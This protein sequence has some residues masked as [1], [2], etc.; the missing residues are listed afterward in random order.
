MKY[1]ART[2]QIQYSDDEN[3]SGKLFNQ[4]LV[5]TIK[6]MDATG[7]YSKYE[8]VVRVHNPPSF[9]AELEA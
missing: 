8:Q 2:H 3:A 1:D 5:N 4:H 9:A 6:L 7:A